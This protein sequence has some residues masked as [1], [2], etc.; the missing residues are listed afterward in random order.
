MAEVTTNGGLFKVDPY[1]E[2]DAAKGSNT[3]K[4]CGLDIEITFT[5]GETV[6]SDK[7]SFVQVMKCDKGGSPLL[8]ANE[9]PRATKSEDGEE[10]WTVDRLSGKK[11]ANYGENNDGT[12]SGA[13]ASG[14]TSVF[15]NR[16]SATAHKNAWMLDA[17]RLSRNAGQTFK[18][19]A[20]TFALDNTNSKYLGA[21]KWGYDVTAAG[22]VTN[23]KAELHSM[24]DPGGVQKKA[25]G[26][27]ND[28]AKN[29]DNGKRNHPDQKALP[30]P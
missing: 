18:C 28:Q 12:A 24:G 14:G 23:Q 15:G 27:W 25:I 3:R 17:V 7:I 8:F 1:K 26:K 22:A 6:R 10:G 13:K 5:P 2:F 29:A 21:V 20:T 30:V 11:S 9:K 16:T 19:T 4:Q